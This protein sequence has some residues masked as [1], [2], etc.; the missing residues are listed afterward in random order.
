MSV[1][2]DYPWR[3]GNT[4]SDV[5]IERR[6]R[7]TGEMQVIPLDEAV[8]RLARATQQ[9][10]QKCQQILLAGCKLVTAGYEYELHEA[11]D[12]PDRADRRDY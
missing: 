12:P 5:G 1:S 4:E 11:G 7:L 6:A 3:D 2:R 8:M 10:R 9:P